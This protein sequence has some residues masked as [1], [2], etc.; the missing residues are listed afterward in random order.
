M[1][2]SCCLSGSVSIQNCRSEIFEEK[3]GMAG[4]F[5]RRLSR[6]DTHD[7][8]GVVKQVNNNSLFSGHI[9]RLLTD[10]LMKY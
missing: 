9:N 1:G 5:T 2:G 8:S 6:W 4:Y 3:V 10:Y 7:F